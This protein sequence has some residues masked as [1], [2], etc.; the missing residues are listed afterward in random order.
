MLR[1]DAPVLT[2]HD[3]IGIGLNFDRAPDGAGR[4]RVL[5]VVE[6]Y[7]AGLGDRCRH[8]VEAVKPTGIGNELGALGFEHIPYR[9]IGQF[10]MSMNLGVGNAFVEQPGV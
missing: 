6:A 2:D 10:R 5:V 9:L 4:D 1:N 8:R 3:A 7:Q